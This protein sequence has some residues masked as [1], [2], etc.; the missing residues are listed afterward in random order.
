[1]SV[2]VDR[3]SAYTPQMTLSVFI[4]SD[5]CKITHLAHSTD[6]SASMFCLFGKL[7]HRL[8]G[9]SVWDEQHL[10]DKITHIS[11]ATLRTEFRSMF[12][13]RIGRVEQ[14]SDR[15]RQCAEFTIKF[16]ERVRTI[17]SEMVKF[18]MIIG[19]ETCDLS[20]RMA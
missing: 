17:S 6:I 5:D 1:L 10:L 4:N 13:N 14:V 15:R 3:A 20:F 12:Q 16:S 18:S 8:I 11:D 9:Q 2:Q 7:R 19:S